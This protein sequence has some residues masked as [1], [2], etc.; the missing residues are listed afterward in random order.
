MEGI[1]MSAFLGFLPASQ[2]TLNEKIKAIKPDRGTALRDS[3]IKGSELM[4]R[5]HVQWMEGG[6]AQKMNTH[7][8]H[9]VLTD[10]MDNSSKASFNDVAEM[11]F[12]MGRLIPSKILKTYFIGVDL[13]ED[14]KA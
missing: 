11:Q 9:I 1:V 6:L 14:P 5:L 10:G 7:F 3:Y 13:H 2:S 12:V 8:V 4:L